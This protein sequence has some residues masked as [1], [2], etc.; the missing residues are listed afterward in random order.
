MGVRGDNG[1]EARGTLVKRSDP[2]VA[3]RIRALLKTIITPETCRIEDSGVTE[4]VER[5]TKSFE[6]DRDQLKDDS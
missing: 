5:T 4:N 3:G 6:K 2:V 1:A